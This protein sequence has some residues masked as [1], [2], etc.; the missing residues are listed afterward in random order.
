MSQKNSQSFSFNKLD[1]EMDKP[2]EKS[3]FLQDPTG[4]E[5]TSVT[6]NLERLDLS[7]C[8]MNSNQPN[9]INN[10]FLPM[11]QLKSTKAIQQ[12]IYN[13]RNDAGSWLVPPSPPECRPSWNYVKNRP[14]ITF[15]STVNMIPIFSFRNLKEELKN[16]SPEREFYKQGTDK[17]YK[18]DLISY[19]YKSTCPPNKKVNT[20]PLY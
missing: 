5:L 7:P 15:T 18:A 6:K 1:I 8:K 12:V 20:R 17:W 13:R 2:K 14:L 11:N 10:I 19:F 9:N 16:P 3:C 4:Y